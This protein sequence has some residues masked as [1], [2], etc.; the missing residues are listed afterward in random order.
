MTRMR[1]TVLGCS[2]SVTGPDSPASGYL[3][4]A[5][6]T[7]PLVIDFGP[8]V[9]GALQR[10]ADPGEVT[11]L[12]SHL[13]ADHCLDLPGLLVWR[14]YHPNPPSG[15]GLVYGPA[16]TA[17]R[18][19]ASS[20]ECAGEMDDISDAIDVRLWTENTPVKIGELT[21][22][23]RR[24]NHPPEAYGFRVTDADGR[25]LAYT[26]DTGMCD[27]VVDL[28]RGADVL[29]C[30]ASWTDSPDRPEGVHLSGKEAGR[31]ATLAGV[32]ELLLTHIPPW[33]S[34]EDVIAEAKS[35]YSGPV[36]AVSQGSVYD[37]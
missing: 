14:R 29:L 22:F 2:G 34:R 21:V 6:G 28:A 30:E 9:L 17:Y 20:A 36:H 13:H 10:H 18:I 35:E 7:P 24:M 32:K 27:N 4:T 31:V 12:L 8:G 37:I 23:P 26:G 5:P 3:L 15:R 11:I 16:D 33:T 1:M 19:G 25:V